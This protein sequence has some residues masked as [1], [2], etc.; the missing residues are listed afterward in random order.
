MQLR[1]NPSRSRF[2][3]I[4]PVILGTGLVIYLLR[5]PLFQVAILITGASVI[6]FLVEPLAVIY[7]KKVSRPPAAL[8]A[9]LS[10]ASA[11]ILFL[12][13][14]LPVIMRE[15]GNLAQTIPQAFQKISQLGSRAISLLQNH[16]PGFS[17]P[18]ISSLGTG[19]MVSNLAGGTIAVAGDIAGI[20]AKFSL[21]AVL[22]YFL[23]CDRSNLMLRLELL[24]PQ[25]VRPIA[26]N[27]GNA[28][29]RELRL[30]LRGQMLVALTIGL[31][32]AIALMIIG[33][34]SAFV[35][36]PIIGILNM[37]PYL[38]PFIGGIPAVL[39]A[40]GDGWQKVALTIGVLFLIQQLDGSFISPRIM[41]NV[42][43]LSPAMV[44]IAIFAGAQIAGVVGMLFALPVIMA[45]RTLFRVFVQKY[46]NI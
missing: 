1:L 26:V 28:V 18:E 13:V 9:L 44:L 34:D 39:V 40:L 22:S 32:S 4:I 25:H 31:I 21:M 15:F 30:Y 14:F 46:E 19:S 23:L 11:L 41:G 37:I 42:T 35:L 20:A 33:V 17:F 6:A 24:V 5:K 38:G 45:I 7:E 16:F 27:M 3:K 12:W 2:F 8:A 10:A 43:G 36:G 29:C